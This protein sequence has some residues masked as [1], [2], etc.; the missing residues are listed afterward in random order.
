MGGGGGGSDINER[1]DT[2]PQDPAC[3]P[4]RGSTGV[5][6]SKRLQV[7]KGKLSP[8]WPQQVPN[9]NHKTEE[10]YIHV[11]LLCLWLRNIYKEVAGSLFNYFL[12]NCTHCASMNPQGPGSVDL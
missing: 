2:G 12:W 9:R 1:V 4:V 5:Y 11:G 10:C 3:E 6:K 7:V 8:P